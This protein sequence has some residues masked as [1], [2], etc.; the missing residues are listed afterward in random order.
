MT[1]NSSVRQVANGD[2]MLVNKRNLPVIGIML[3][4]CLFGMATAYYPGGT[5]DSADFVGYS[6]KKHFIST[7]FATKALN[8]ADNPARYFAVPAMLIFCTSMAAMFWYV[9]IQSRSIVLSKAINIGGIGAMVYAFLAVTTPMH[10]LLV[11]VALVFFL[12]ALLAMLSMLYRARKTKLLFVGTALLALLVTCAVMYY[13]NV[14]FGL[15]PIAQKLVFALGTY[16]LLAL[17]F[18]KFSQDETVSVQ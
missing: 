8:G 3:S 9:S 18:S 6:W 1:L 16:W 11:S 4:L 2:S 12:A 17:H 15:L 5:L 13:A 7:L 10:D 14:L